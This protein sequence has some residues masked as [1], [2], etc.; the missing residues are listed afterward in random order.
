M[1]K[2]M[3]AN[4]RVELY[5]RFTE[6]YRQYADDPA[7][8]EIACM[9][10]QYPLWM[11]PVEEGD[12]WA[13][14]GEFD[15]EIGF[16]PQALINKFGYFI[17]IPKSEAL[18][19]DPSLTR[20]NRDAFEELIGYWKTEETVYR[21]RQRYPESMQRL[22]PSDNWQGEAGI[23][24]PL[25]RM[26]GTQLDFDK[27]LRKGLPALR[28]ET[29]IYLAAAGTECGKAFY[30]QILA[31]FDLFGEVAEHY[32]RQALE[33][34]R[35]AR[36]ERRSELRRMADALHRI[37]TDRPATLYEAIQLSYLYCQ[38]SGSINFGRMD[39]YL[40][41]FLADDLRTG[42]L[43]RQSAILLIGRYWQLIEKR[44]R[45]Y[46]SRLTIGGRGRRN[47]QNADFFALCA[48]EA[49]RRV[50]TVAP[51]ITLRFHKDQHPALMTAALDAIGAGCTFPMLYNDEVNIPAVQ[52]AFG[53]SL[54]EAENYIPFGCGEYTLYHKSVGTPSGVI[55]L[56]AAL[57][58]TLR[59][60]EYPTFEALMDAYKR[61]VELHVEQLALQEKMEYD[62]AGETA[63]FLLISALYDDCMQKGLPIFNGGVR[64]LGGTLESY[65]GTNTADSL[66]A[67]RELVYEKH[68]LTIPE[69]LRILE[70]NFAGYEAERIRMKNLPKYGND[71]DRA[72][73]LKKE[74]DRHIC[75]SAIEAGKRAGLDNY[76]IVF[77]NNDAN[78]ILGRY[79]GASP[80]GRRAGTSMANGNAPSGGC[81]R[82]GITALLN[83]MVKPDVRIHAG[84]VQNIKLSQ[85]LFAEYRSQLEALLKGYFDHGGAQLMI[86]AVN[87]GD[88]ENALREPDKYRNL[89]VRVGGFSARFVELA[90]DVQQEI[91]SRTLY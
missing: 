35:T 70:S 36:G 62:M 87:R 9:R 85:S 51:Q 33:Q 90:P 43:D 88:L 39:E 82:N 15:Q 76:L 60:E 49:M 59:D 45:V 6:A 41:D 79:T 54:A 4:A 69:L 73:C 10:I 89:T 55:N 14:R 47:P 71:D 78:T 8:R 56:L 40:G 58:E 23:A 3:D 1:N 32:E 72:D 38:L 27:L 81:D 84:A 75:L 22:L 48:M 63:P 42:R 46:D 24:F 11:L 5:L 83:S 28:R 13:G 61:K 16:T 19:T 34:M 12:W 2:E 29:E 68:E 26:S 17:D 86:T 50:K 7:Q 31:G 37:T 67:I 20:Q 80:D 53:V 66:V 30:R 21:L 25:Y 44:M 77:I 64:C 57:L 18:L 74:I 52:Q 65:G 91:L